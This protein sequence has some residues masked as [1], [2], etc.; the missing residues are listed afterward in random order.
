[1]PVCSP[2]I[3]SSRVRGKPQTLARAPADILSGM[4][5][6]SRRTSPGCMGLS[7]LIIAASLLMVIHDFDLRRTLRRP[8]EA[9]PE[10]VVNADRVL[11]P[12]IARE[13]LKTI[14]GRRPQIAKIARGA[15]VT[16]FPARHLDQISRKALRALAVEDGF[17][18]LVPEA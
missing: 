8:N 10:L 5:N 13:C 7:F 2:A 9:H 6:S 11:S 12:A 18:N 17:G 3:R 14:A 4:R 15:E 1:M 16:Q